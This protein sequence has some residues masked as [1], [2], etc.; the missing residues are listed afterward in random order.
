MNSTQQPQ[1]PV[2][3]ASPIRKGLV[4]LVVVLGGF[5][6]W[7]SLA[8]LN[9]G[10]PL[11]GV[12]AVESKRKPVQH[13]NGGIVASV[14]V[15]EGDTVKAGDVLLTLDTSTS[16]GQ[17]DMTRSQLQGLQAQIDGLRQQI[18]LRERQVASL[19]QDIERLTPLAREQL[20]PRNRLEEQRRQL[21]Q[22]RSQLNTDKT[23]L[24]Q[25]MAQLSEQQERLAVLSTEVQRAVVHAPSA[26]VVL[27]LTV[28]SPGAV[29]APGA[30]IMEIVP[31]SDSL[32]VDVQVPPHLITSVRA[33]LMAQLRFPALDQRKT[34]VIDGVVQRVSADSVTDREGRSFYTARLTVPP[35]ELARLNGVALQPGM[36]VEGIVITGERT[37]LNYLMKPLSDNFARS[38]KER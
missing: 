12:V 18:P 37:F 27:G 20:Y 35:A 6:A 22:L 16:S 32:V 25:A 33:G 15:K 9:E 19:H 34:P 8:P 17:A 14:R 23:T 36:P 4:G 28:N 26:G 10:V 21:D 38:L 13:L 2:N 5:L 11:P 3:V 24:L 1:P 29:I 31:Q 30:Q 7:A